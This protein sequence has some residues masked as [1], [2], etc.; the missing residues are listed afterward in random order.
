MTDKVKSNIVHYDEAS[1]MAQDIVVKGISIDLPPLR[2]TKKS[3]LISEFI[4]KN[5]YNFKSPIVHFFSA[6]DKEGVVSIALNVALL[7]SEKFGKK[8]LVVDACAD[9]VGPF[10]TKLRAEARISINDLCT[11]NGQGKTPFL[12]IE[13]TTFFYAPLVRKEE[14][15][16]G[17]IDI[18][19]LKKFLVTARGNFDF[20]IL[21]SE[22]SVKT[23]FVFS[24]SSISQLNILTVSSQKMRRQVLDHIIKSLSDAHAVLSATILS[25]RR[26]FIPSSLYKWF[27][28]AS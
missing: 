5:T 21:A 9:D 13:N 2:T 14:M 10:I 26:Y 3:S 25:D 11:R 23:R 28:S 4:E 18:T 22:M 12:N 6:Y 8:V 17:L 16:S 24:L 27:V 1:N 20:V 19:A 7:L 15:E